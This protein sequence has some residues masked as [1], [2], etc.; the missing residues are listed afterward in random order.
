MKMILRRIVA[1][2]TVAFMSLPS[3]AAVRSEVADAAMRSDK[4]ALRTL[5]EQHADVNAS[6]PDGAT[7]LHWA[8]YRGDKEMADMLIRAGAN[9]KATNRDGVTPLWLASINGDAA[10]ITMLL[11]AGADPNEHLLLGRSPLMA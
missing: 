2:L 4:A 11:T 7:A 1:M 8:V 3:F 10:I 6:Q 5:L 9:P